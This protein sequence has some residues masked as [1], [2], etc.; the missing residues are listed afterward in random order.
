MNIY[1]INDQLFC[2]LIVDPATAKV[3][4]S[5]IEIQTTKTKESQKENEC[6]LQRM[7]ADDFYQSLTIAG[8]SQCSQISCVTSDRL[9][10]SGVS[11]LILKKLIKCPSTSCK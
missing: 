9:W 8:V 3:M 4:E 7:S 6:Q 5:L 1:L 11:D 2:F 10:I